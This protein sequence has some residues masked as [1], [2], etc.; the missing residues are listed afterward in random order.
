MELVHGV[1]SDAVIEEQE[2][3]TKL[4]KDLFV[5]LSPF[6]QRLDSSVLER[7]LPPI[8]QTVIHVRQTKTQA[9]LYRAFKK[10][11]QQSESN[12]FL[13]QYSKLFLVN[14]HPGSLLCRRSS[15]SKRRKESLE[16]QDADKTNSPA[17]KQESSP[18]VAAVPIEKDQTV[19]DNSQGSVEVIVIDDSDE[20]DDDTAEYACLTTGA[21]IDGEGIELNA[22]KMELH[23]D[24]YINDSSDKNKEEW[25]ER[26]YR[27]HPNMGAIQNGGKAMLLL[28]ILAHSESIGKLKNLIVVSLNSLYC[29]LNLVVTKGDK[30]VVFSQ[31]LKTL[32]YIESII[33]TPN[34]ESKLPGLKRFNKKGD[35]IG[36]WKN[37]SDYLRIDG[38]VSASERGILIN[39]FNGDKPLAIPSASLVDKKVEERAKAFL[40]SSKAGSV[41]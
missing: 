9:L 23:Q 36:G 26:V 18:I 38:S 33:N 6:I 24:D 32:D 16:L 28:Q 40:I 5:T 21:N 31:C 41:G 35:H 25:W 3:G 19:F 34:W 20:E 10:Y 1:Q 39:Q 4:L 14:N 12:N 7:D 27:K 15:K 17:L 29:P 30:V 2:L 13:E 37:G 11:Q 22:S 8:Q